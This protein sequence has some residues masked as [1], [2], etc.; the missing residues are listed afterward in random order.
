MTSSQFRELMSIRINLEGSA[1]EHACA[2]MNKRSFAKI[3]AFAC[4]YSKE[5]GQSNPNGV[6]LANINMNL[7]FSIYRVSEMPMLLQL[8]ET[9]WLRIGPILNYDMRCSSKRIEVL[10][11]ADHRTRLV[12]TLSHHEKLIKALKA[13]DVKGAKAALKSD[14]ETASEFIVSSGTLVVSD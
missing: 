14:I 2:N 12:R 1:T 7:H 3:E 9:L 4:D 8:I 5:L 10:T 6:K 13:G 11:M